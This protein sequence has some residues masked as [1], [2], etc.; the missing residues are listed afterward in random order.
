MTSAHPS[1]EH[2]NAQRREAG[3]TVETSTCAP[4]EARREALEEIDPGWCPA[5]DAGW[6]RC[7]RLTQTHVQGGGAVSMAAGE[8]VVQGEDLGR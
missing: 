1:I 2:Q 5:W 8:V 6:Q 4:T 7:F 3:L